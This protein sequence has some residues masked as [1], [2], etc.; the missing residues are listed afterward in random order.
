MVEEKKRLTTTEQKLI[1][2]LSRLKEYIL[3]HTTLG[4][5]TAII[6]LHINLVFGLC[7]FTGFLWYEYE[8]FKEIRRIIKSGNLPA[9][10]GSIDDSCAKDTRDYLYGFYGWGIIEVLMW[11]EAIIMTR[12]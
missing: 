9:D 11:V 4:A 5:I 3:S 1:D 6:I 12:R 7:C 8:E 10:I 2:G